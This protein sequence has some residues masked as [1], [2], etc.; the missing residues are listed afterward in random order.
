MKTDVPLLHNLEFDF[1]NQAMYTLPSDQSAWLYHR[2]L[3]AQSTFLQLLLILILSTKLFL[4]KRHKC[5]QK[6]NQDHSR[7]S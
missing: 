1:V 7:S 2:W 5:Y 3:I 6:G 4:S